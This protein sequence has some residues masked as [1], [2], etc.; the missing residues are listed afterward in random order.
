MWNETEF[1]KILNQK[2]LSILQDKLTVN[3]LALLIAPEHNECK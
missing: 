1:N 2:I 3:D